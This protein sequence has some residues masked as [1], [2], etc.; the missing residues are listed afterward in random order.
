MLNSQTLFGQPER[1][2]IEQRHLEAYQK[3][4]HII[5]FD[6]IYLPTSLLNVYVQD[7]QAKSGNL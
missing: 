3:K 2:Y 7:D 5:N 6:L 1:P 4:A